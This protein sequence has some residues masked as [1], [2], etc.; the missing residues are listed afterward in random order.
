MK[1]V[2]L[3]AH[4]NCRW[5]MACSSQIPLLSCVK[6]VARSDKWRSL[7]AFDDEHS[8]CPLPSTKEIADAL[9]WSL[10][11]GSYLDTGCKKVE[12]LEQNKVDLCHKSLF[13]EKQEKLSSLCF[14]PFQIFDWRRNGFFHKLLQS[15]LRSS[16]SCR[17]ESVSI[18]L[19]F[20]FS[21]SLSL[22]SWKDLMQPVTRRLCIRSRA[23]GQLWEQLFHTF[24]GTCEWH[25]NWHFC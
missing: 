12:R 3:N 13:S 22:C 23:A 10:D 9:S 11:T 8:S 24:T 5:F 18:F 21:L 2:V 7:K 14:A 16:F 6:K 17:T 19:G 25:L 20:H 4:R 15:P 1:N